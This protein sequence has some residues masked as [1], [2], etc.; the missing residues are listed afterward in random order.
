MIAETLKPAFWYA[1]R[2]QVAIDELAGAAAANCYCGECAVC[3]HRWVSVGDEDEIAVLEFPFVSLTGWFFKLGLV[4]DCGHN[5]QPH[6]VCLHRCS[7]C[8][9]LVWHAL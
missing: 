4:S 6:Q 2:C 3:S 7:L 5:H 8:A 9:A 1:S